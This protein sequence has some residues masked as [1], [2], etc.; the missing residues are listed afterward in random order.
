MPGRPSERPVFSR[1]GTRP[2]ER[3]LTT[4]SSRA[5]TA[6]R[7]GPVGGT[8]CIFANRARASHRRCRLN[9]NVRRHNPGPSSVRNYQMEQVLAR[10]VQRMLP[11]LVLA[12]SQTSCTFPLKPLS[13]PTTADTTPK[14]TA[15]LIEA[16]ANATVCANPASARRVP[17]SSFRYGCFCGA[18]WPAIDLQ[19]T[20]NLTSKIVQPSL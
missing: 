13:E 19:S 2:V 18:G 11:F 6:G 5:P 12:L 8:W 1:A 14:L 4:R 17:N 15:I 10:A 16:R 3:G 7:A 9:S 20:G